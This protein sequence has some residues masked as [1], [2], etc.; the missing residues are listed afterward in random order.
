MRNYPTPLPEKEMGPRSTDSQQRLQSFP[1][2]HQP[3][4]ASIASH[5]S[6]DRFKRSELS[7]LA[8]RGEMRERI[9][10]FDWSKTAIGAIGTW[11]PGLKTMVQILLANRFP[12]LLWWGPDFIQIYNDAYIPVLGT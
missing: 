9:R 8:G 12:M 10:N 6:S 7:F 11:T 4:A 3:S 1:A 5:S 2:N